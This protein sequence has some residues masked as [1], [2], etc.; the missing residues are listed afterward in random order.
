M[1]KLIPIVIA[2]LVLECLC[3]STSAQRRGNKEQLYLMSKDVI[4]AD[5]KDEY[6]QAR[7]ELISVC[8]ET[9]FPHPFILWS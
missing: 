9:G 5:K 7:Q 6:I 1:K 3:M 8:E 2:L 4:K